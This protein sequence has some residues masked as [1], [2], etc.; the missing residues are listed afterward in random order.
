MNRGGGEEGMEI[1]I[2]EGDRRDGD[3]GEEGGMAVR[4]RREKEGLGDP[5]RGEMGKISARGEEP[6]K[7]GGAFVIFFFLLTNPIFVVFIP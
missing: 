6:Q 5:A 1:L 7:A 4:V 2:A 3:P